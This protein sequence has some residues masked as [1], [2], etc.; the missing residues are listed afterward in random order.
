VRE[1]YPAERDVVRWSVSLDPSGTPPE[2]EAMPS[3]EL[4]I[5]VSGEIVVRRIASGGFPRLEVRC[6]S[7]VV[8][9]M[10]GYSWW[11][12]YFR[13]GQRILLPTG[14]EWTLRA[15][16]VNRYVCPLI[17]DDRGAPVATTSVGHRTYGI[18]GERYAFSLNP[19]GRG[20][21]PNDW[22]LWRFDEVGA[23]SRSPLRLFA[24]NPIPLPVALLGFVL[25]Q[26]GIPGETPLGIPPIRWG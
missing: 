21:R 8:A 25:I 3:P 10:G 9:R 15:V 13:R 2:P 1:A 18:S 5:E 17:V 7:E 19:A 4:G 12:I 24:V 16:G 6:G 11:G 14:R 22:T 23:M 20:R 26:Y